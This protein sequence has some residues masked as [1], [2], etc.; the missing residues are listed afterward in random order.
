MKCVNTG[1]DYNAVE[2]DEIITGGS[3]QGR[4]DSNSFGGA[5]AKA[6]AKWHSEMTA[7]LASD[8]ARNDNARTVARRLTAQP[9]PT[10]NVN[11]AGRLPTGERRVRHYRSLLIYA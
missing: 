2:I 8:G 4:S 6:A 5:G 3:Q 7:M 11:F 1:A 10:A 9:K